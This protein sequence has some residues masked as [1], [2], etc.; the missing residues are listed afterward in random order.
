M[1]WRRCYCRA[2]IVDTAWVLAVT[3]FVAALAVILVASANSLNIIWSDGDIQQSDG[4][5]T[6]VR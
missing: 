5:G 1:E 2:T 6:S 3:V 4:N